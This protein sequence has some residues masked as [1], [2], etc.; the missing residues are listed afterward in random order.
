M[1]D[2][3]TLLV[4]GA[5]GFLG[6]DICRRALERGHAVRGLVRA[7]SDADRVSALRDMGV[8]PITGNLRDADS[9]RE[10]LQGVDTVIST[11]TATRTRREDEQLEDVDRE[12]QR[13]L[14]RLATA[15]GVRRFVYISFSGGIGVD[16]PLT[17]A[18]RG[19]EE[20][21]RSSGMTY[22]ILRPSCFMEAWLSP[23]LGFDYPNARATVYGAGT[24]AVSWI[25]LADVAEFAVL[26]LERPE[27]DNA[28]IE[29]GGPEPLSPLEV[30]AIFER[31]SGREFAVQH[32]PEA[33]LERQLETAGDS[34]HAAFAALMLAVAAG[35]PIPMDHVLATYPVRLLSV[36]EYARQALSG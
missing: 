9:I 22:T 1:E 19:N 32:V 8:T 27:A 15:A 21:V 3:L 4:V 12:G 30:I 23:A 29:L 5:T 31:E 36:R 17:L 26:A 14:I 10:A 18:K 24:N 35:N 11:A 13:Q 28:V 6:S 16:D 7:T 25:S 34:L 2:A 33:E 20:A